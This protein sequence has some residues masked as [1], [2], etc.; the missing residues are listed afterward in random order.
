VQSPAADF[1]VTLTDGTTNV[2]VKGT[3][4]EASPAHSNGG[5]VNSTVVTITPATPLVANQTINVE[6]T[7]GVE[8]NGEFRFFVNVEAVTQAAPSASVHLTMGNPSNATPDV[9]Q[10]TNYLLVKEGYALAYHRDRGTP[11]WTS[12]HLDPTWLGSA[13]RQNDFRNDPSLPSG[14]IRCRGRTIRVRASTGDT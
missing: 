9:N 10:P 12:W 6:F 1:N 13:P 2:P 14:G 3:Q 11:V 4:V 5:G 7:L 8:R